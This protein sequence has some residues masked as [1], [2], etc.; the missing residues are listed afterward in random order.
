MTFFFSLNAFLSSFHLLCFGRFEEENRRA[1]VGK[2]LDLLL[3]PKVKK[4]KTKT[5]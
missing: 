4:H 1:D 2:D 3:L 5:G